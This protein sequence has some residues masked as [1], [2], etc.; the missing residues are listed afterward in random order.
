MNLPELEQQTAE[1]DRKNG[2]V[3]IAIAVVAVVIVAWTHGTFDNFLWRVHLNYTTCGM[4]GFG[5]TFCGKDYDQYNQRLQQA[6][7]RVNP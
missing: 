7:I 5:A 6:G 4:N 2:R 1:R 3:L